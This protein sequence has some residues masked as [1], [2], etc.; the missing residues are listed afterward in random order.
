MIYLVRP[1]ALAMQTRPLKLSLVLL[2]TV[3]TF[4]GFAIAQGAPQQ[5]ATPPASGE[6][7]PDAAAPGNADGQPAQ[8][9]EPLPETPTQNS[10]QS[11]EQPPAE[12]KP[13]ALTIATWGGAYEQAQ[14]RAIFTPYAASS[15]VSI[16]VETYDGSLGALENAGGRWDVVDLNSAE[17]DAGC[18][19]G[20][21]EPI[22]QFGSE[23]FIPAAIKP[24][25][26][27][28]AVWSSVIVHNKTAFARRAP[29]SVKDFFDLK[30]FPGKRALRK[31][32][33]YILELALMADGV[34]SAAVYTT[35]S[36]PEG[37]DR[38]FKRLD[39]I[40]SAVIWRDEPTGALALV[41]KG[42]AAMGLAF[43]GRAFNAMIVNR[44]P[45]ALVWDA[46]IYDIDYW[47]IPKGSKTMSAAVEFIRF[48]TEPEKQ[49]A[50]AS[51]IPY[52]PTRT[53]ALALVGKHAHLDMEMRPHLPT[54][55]ENSKRALFIDEAWW[56]D[57]GGAVNERFAAW[58]AGVSAPERAAGAQTSPGG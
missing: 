43:N 46:Q 20:L 57:N 33:R 15:G 9:V 4:S 58:L 49:A 16:N 11:A 22:S 25:A 44:Q 39:G 36:A 2:T 42:D 27:G 6:T 19:K 56:R 50:M 31:S 48:A 18:E 28:G 24:C 53:S 29:S 54:A 17:A 32:P 30:A 38:A 55:P 40:K 52:G 47:A 51:Y 5:D 1:K 35:L 14:K 13:A 23:D 45:I 10:P 26:I 7:R 8:A 3:V 21:L 41:G 37:L 34:E 12:T